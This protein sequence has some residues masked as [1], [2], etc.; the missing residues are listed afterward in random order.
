MKVSVNNE[1][2]PFI[3]TSTLSKQVKSIYSQLLGLVIILLLPITLLAEGDW[4]QLNPANSPEA[5]FGHS[6]VTLPNGRV[7]MFGGENDVGDVFEEIVMWAD[8]DVWDRL[9]PGGNPPV[10]RKGPS[11]VVMPDGEVIL[12]GGENGQLYHDMHVFTDNTWQSVI[13]AN[14]PPPP[15]AWHA[16]GVLIDGRMVVVGGKGGLSDFLVDLWFFDW[17]AQRW[18]QGADAPVGYQGA[19]VATNDDYVYVLGQWENGKI[20]RYHIAHN[21]WDEITPNGSFP[22]NQR[23]FPLV[24]QYGN[25]VFFGGGKGYDPN[26]GAQVIHQDFWYFDTSTETWT[27]LEDL[28]LPLYKSAAAAFTG[29][30]VHVIVFGGITEGELVIGDTYEYINADISLGIESIGNKPEKFALSQNYPNPFN[31]VTTIQ[32]NVLK[33]VHVELKV[34]NLLGREIMTLI[35]SKYQP[36]EHS[37]T[38]NASQLSAGIYFYKVIMGDYTAVKKMVHIK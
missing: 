37:V 29:N 30:S 24:A 10:A 25:K 22:P 23:N 13:P 6:M 31:P 26:V 18:E 14:D 20:F 35:D 16:T 36:G 28:P 2:N 8:G 9:N 15:R 32:I 5:R 4:D 38:F 27:Q 21:Q 17:A 19:A 33:A 34:H 12:F 7:I 11:M 1:S 3:K